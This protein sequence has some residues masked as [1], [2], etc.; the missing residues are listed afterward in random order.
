M[1]KASY[2]GFCFIVLRYIT[3]YIYLATEYRIMTNIEFSKIRVISGQKHD[4]K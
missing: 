1:S 4:A 2:G 3:Y